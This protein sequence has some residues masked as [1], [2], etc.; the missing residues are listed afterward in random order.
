ETGGR[1][2]QF[3]RGRGRVFSQDEDLVAPLLEDPARLAGD[4][5]QD[6]DERSLVEV[7]GDDFGGVDLCLVEV[8]GE[9]GL[10]L[11]QAEALFRRLA[12][13]DHVQV[14]RVLAP[15]LYVP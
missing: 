7:Q 15:G 6:G 1:H 2:F 3:Y 13:D 11:D 10:P 12:A 8:K 4:G 14:R 9:A 5:L